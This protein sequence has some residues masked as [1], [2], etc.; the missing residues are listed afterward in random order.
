[1]SENSGDRLKLSHRSKSTV[2]ADPGIDMTGAQKTGH[3]SKTEGN[4]R[5]LEEENIMLK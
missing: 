4:M 1:M 5:Y 3:N 2:Y